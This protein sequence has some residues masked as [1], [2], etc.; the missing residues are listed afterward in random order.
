MSFR[1]REE[2]YPEEVHKMRTDYSH[3]SFPNGEAMF[4]VYRRMVAVI[5]EIAEENEGKTV[6]IAT[7]AGALRN[8]LAFANGYSEE[9]VHRIRTG[10]ENANIHIHEWENGSV[11]IVLSY[12]KEHLGNATRVTD[13][14][15]KV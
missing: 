15:K 2:R 3:M 5:K 10:G 12:F 1:E 9:E 8:Y 13:D 4:E 7:H 14:E 11:R 6:L